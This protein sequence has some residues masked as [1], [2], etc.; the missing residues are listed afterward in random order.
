MLYNIGHQFWVII[1]YLKDVA[2]ENQVDNVPKD[3]VPI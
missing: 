2:T 1:L 3:R